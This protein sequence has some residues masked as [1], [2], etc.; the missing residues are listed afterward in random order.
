MKATISNNIKIENPTLSVYKWC[1]DN[2]IIDNPTYVKLEKLGKEDTIR[3]THVSKKI[4]L[5]YERKGI[6]NSLLV[7][8]FGCVYGIW[9]LIKDSEILTS[10]S[11][12]PF[13]SIKNI[14]CPWK[15]KNYQEDSINAL[16]NAKGGVLQSGCGSGKTLVGI[17]IIHRI[18][19]RFLWI[20]GTKD[21][22]SQAIGDFLELYPNMNIGTITDGEVKM[23][24]DGTVSTVQTLCKIDPDIYA[25]EF[26]TVVV[27]ECHR[28][29]A[30]PENMR[31]YEKVL[32]KVKA[33]YRFGLTATAFRSDSLT[34]TIF[35]NIGMNQ[36][37]EFKPVY[38]VDRNRISS[39]TAQYVRVETNI[40]ESKDYLDF[41]GVIVYFKL[42]KYLYENE[43]R[44]NLILEK[45]KSLLSEGRKIA[46]LSTSIS[47]CKKLNEMFLQNG[48][49]SCIV[50]GKT[51]ASTRKNNLV[52]YDSWDVIVSDVPLFKEGIDIV[53]LDTIEL[54]APIRDKVSVIQS[55]GRTEREKEGKNQPLFIDFVDNRISYCDHLGF[56]RERYLK[57]RT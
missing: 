50:I 9:P 21:L 46:V 18:G 3:R 2:L 8:P 51:K 38:E 35:T 10:F 4:N 23:G 49:K 54:V 16:L 42:V 41:D 6:R 5:F 17:E 1:Q 34:K 25:N 31:M 15:L 44:N 53:S 24:E 26:T 28:A 43:A 13:I 47:H 45:T 39:L 52:N 57:N 33:R 7:L 19:K 40:Q 12:S 14:P 48:I 37:G 27:D 20:C 29:A 32:N 30:N 11:D 55:C 36:N 56:L 22:L